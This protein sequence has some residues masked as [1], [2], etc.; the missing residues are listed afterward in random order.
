MRGQVGG[1]AP[2]EN[3]ICTLKFG[4][5][6]FSWVMSYVDFFQPS[7]GEDSSSSGDR[8]LEVGWVWPGAGRQGPLQDALSC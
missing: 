7:R 3:F 1:S 6:K 8:P 4:L 2:P 5:R